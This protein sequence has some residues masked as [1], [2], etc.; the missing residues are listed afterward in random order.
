VGSSGQVAHPDSPRG[1]AGAGHSSLPASLGTERNG[2]EPLPH[3]QAPGARN[4][5]VTG[6][7]VIELRRDGVALDTGTVGEPPA[8]PLANAPPK[9]APDTFHVTRKVAGK[10]DTDVKVEVLEDGTDLRAGRDWDA[11]TFL[12]PS[13]LTQDFPT[14]EISTADQNKPPSQQKV[15]QLNGVYS[16]TGTVTI[17]IRY[18][19]LAKPTSPAA[20]GRGT[21]AD[22][23]ARGDTTMGFHESRH[24]ADF[25]QWLRGRPL[26]QFT[27]KVGDS[28]QRYKKA[29]D[30]CAAALDKH[31]RDAE[32]H[33]RSQ[34]DQVGSPTLSEYQQKHPG[35][36]HMD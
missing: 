6:Q 19:S 34:T 14:Y 22:D 18:G 28:V 20:F 15:V 16:I 31:F 9:T 5:L 26:P 27:G 8:V 23:R 30:E 2:T 33:S 3:P 17:Q 11:R 32:A 4:R 36:S 7:D 21:T 25:V 10:E 13:G 1:G 24:L 12:D 35:F 29:C